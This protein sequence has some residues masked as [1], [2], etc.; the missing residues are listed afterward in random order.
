MLPYRFRWV[1]CQLE[2]LRH[3]L[4]ASIR[5]TLDQLPK[6]LDDT[7]LR[8]LRQIPQANQAHARRMLQ[9]LMVAIR[10]L[11]VEE[12]AELLAFEFDAAQDG[13]PKY[14]PALRLDDQTQAVLSTCSSLVTI[15][16]DRWSYRP[17]VVQFSHFSVKEFLVSNRLAPLLGDISQFRIH[18]G[19]AHT[20]SHRPV[21]DYFSI[22]T[23]TLPKRGQNPLLWLTMQPDTGSS[24]H[25]LRMLRHT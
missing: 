16:S 1:F 18:L 9:C 22:W 3:C 19:S 10:P 14:H 15:I 2:V 5:K 11:G 8:V 13:I 21:S 20:T 6:S 25:N 23:V 4:P 17:Q 12:L 7:Y 24:T